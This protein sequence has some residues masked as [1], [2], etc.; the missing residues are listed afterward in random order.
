M[1]AS[2][3]T[4]EGKPARMNGGKVMLDD[5]SIGLAEFQAG[6]LLACW[7]PLDKIERAGM[8]LA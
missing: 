7:E 3:E 5:S 2:A 8:R 1:R 6:L 4:K